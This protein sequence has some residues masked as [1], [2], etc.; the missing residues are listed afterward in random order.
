VGRQLLSILDQSLRPSEIVISDGGSQDGTVA[1]LEDFVV[2][3]RSAAPETKVILLTSPDEQLDV[4]ANF[5]RAVRACSGEYVA[6]ADQDDVWESERLSASVVALS[7]DT[8]WL[9]GSD[10]LLVDQDGESTR[11]TVFEQFESRLITRGDLVD[12]PLKVLLRQNFIPGMTMTGVRAEFEKLLPVPDGWLHDYWFALNAAVDDRLVVL[13]RPLVRYRQHSSNVLGLSRQISLRRLWAAG[14]GRLAAPQRKES[15][16]A[17]WDTVATEALVRG[18]RADLLDRK[19][20]FESARETVLAE[21]SRVR[22]IRSILAN[23]L[24]YR[25]FSHLGAMGMIRDLI[26]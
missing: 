23:A 4:S 1:I 3:A 18:R 11:T 22:R 19:R 5:A 12:D 20:S 13:D 17:T 16:H 9:A 15:S 14:I 8:A 7:R 2:Q 21:S 25:E 26:S 24:Q 10:A 6:L